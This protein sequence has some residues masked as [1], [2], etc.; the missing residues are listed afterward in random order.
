MIIIVVT[1]I[2][3]DR[4]YSSSIVVIV[5]SKLFQFAGFVTLIL[6]IMYHTTPSTVRDIILQGEGRPY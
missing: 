3:L 5:V 4:I 2:V 6:T 1:I